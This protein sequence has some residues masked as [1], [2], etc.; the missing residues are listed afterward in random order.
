MAAMEGPDKERM[1]KFTSGEV[2]TKEDF[3]ET[4]SLL[5][6][7]FPN[8]EDLESDTTFARLFYTP[9]L[10]RFFL[11]SDDS[12]RPAGV[13]LIRINPHIP[14][15]MYIPY[16]GLA[17]EHIGRNVYPK[18]AQITDAQMRRNGIK[19]ALADVE[20]PTRIISADI[21]RDQDPSQVLQRSE[22]RIRAL[23]E[24]MGMLYIHDPEIPYLRPT[25]DDPKKVQAYDLLGFRP[26]NIRDSMWK[27]VFNEDKT[28]IRKEAYGDMYLKLMQL[29]YGNEKYVPSKEE[30]RQKYPAIDI[31]FTAFDKSSKEWVSL[32]G[33]KVRKKP[34]RRAG[35]GVQA[36]ELESIDERTNKAAIEKL[37]QQLNS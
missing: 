7:V 26:L 15:V 23:K 9:A 11:L 18:M 4:L 33:E 25:S 35:I 14:D 37:R 17:R 30:L 29:E 8:P 19:F 5:K 2:R 12:K 3:Y 34:V 36:R 21:Y 22:R 13:Q 32:Y 28:A 24:N 31:F 16:A 20:D 6:S 10:A 27:N 1:P